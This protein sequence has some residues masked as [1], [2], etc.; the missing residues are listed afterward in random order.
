[1]A[2]S[3]LLYLSAHQMSAFSW[4][5]GVLADEG[6]FDASEAG[7]AAFADYLRGQLEA[8][9][10]RSWPTSRKKV[11]TS[12]PSRSC[13]APTV[14]RSL[15]ASS[16]QL[17]FNAKLVTALSLG[18]QKSRRKDERIMLAALTRPEVF[19]PGSMPWPP[20]SWLSPA[21]IRCPC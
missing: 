13:A 20:P 21:F 11:S 3:R 12:K 16:G 15:R 9:S 7:Q 1:M 17:F 18:H 19:A 5:S 14:R 6:S 8:A 4:Q 2:A 10:S